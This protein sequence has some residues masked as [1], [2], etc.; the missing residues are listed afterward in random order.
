MHIIPTYQHAFSTIDYE[1][2]GSSFRHFVKD[3]AVG[4]IPAPWSDHAILEVNF[5]LGNSKLGPSLW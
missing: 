5:N 1:F 4:F 3:T 2:A